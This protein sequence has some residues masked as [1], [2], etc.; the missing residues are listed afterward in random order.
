MAVAYRKTAKQRTKSM[1]GEGIALPDVLQL[2]RVVR[3]KNLQLDVKIL[4]NGWEPVTQ[5]SVTAMIK[6]IIEGKIKAADDIRL[7]LHAVESI[8]RHNPK[9]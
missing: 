5:A 2:F 6:A 1:L 8:P 4:D 7:R 3:E 9:T